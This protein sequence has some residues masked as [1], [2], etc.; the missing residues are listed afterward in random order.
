VERQLELHRAPAYLYYFDRQMPGDLDPN[1]EFQLT[2]AFHSAELWYEFQTLQRCWR[3]L[4]GKDYDLSLA[5]AEYWANFAKYG[6]PNGEGLPQWEPFT[7]ENP[8]AMELGLDIGMIDAPMTTSQR[9]HTDFILG[10]I[11]P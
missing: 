3:P 2:G 10:R 8:K 5:M 4:T 9:F 11:K 6:D 7:F 1:A